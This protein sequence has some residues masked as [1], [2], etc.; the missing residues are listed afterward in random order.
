MH[1]WAVAAI[2]YKNSCQPR[3]SG[4]YL[5]FGV[6]GEGIYWRVAYLVL[7]ACIWF[8]FYRVSSQVMFLVRG[9]LFSRMFRCLPQKSREGGV[10]ANLSQ[11]ARQICAKLP[12]FRFVHQRKV[13]QH[14][15]KFVANLKWISDNFMHIPLFQCP[16]L[17]ISDWPTILPA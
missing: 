14:C 5:V 16:L 6:S 3:F 7:Q 15:R 11:I 13:A 17:Q 10:R 2:Y 4:V 1:I 9:S 12:V 8:L